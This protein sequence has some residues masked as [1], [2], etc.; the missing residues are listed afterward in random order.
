M[1]MKRNYSVC[2]PDE[3]YALCNRNNWFTCGTNKQ[4]QKLFEAN[5]ELKPLEIIATIIYICSDDSE[6]YD[7]ILETLNEIKNGCKK[8]FRAVDIEWDIDED[9]DSVLPTEVD[10][11][12]D[13]VD[14][15]EEDDYL[16][17]ISDYL[18]DKF[19]Y[20]HKGFRL[21]KVE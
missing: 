14:V 7:S 21:E 1:T 5:E 8:R 9:D 16:D 6:T 13:I 11:S 10:I 15:D 19:G 12:E 3:L 2:G 20:C 18:S 4:Y 17:S